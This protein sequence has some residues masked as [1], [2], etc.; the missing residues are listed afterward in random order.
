M[1]IDFDGLEELPQLNIRK[2]V[3]AV[4]NEGA[5]IASS[6]LKRA[7]NLLDLADK[8]DDF[9]DRLRRA[10]VALAQI[11]KETTE[12]IS[13]VIGAEWDISSPDEDDEDESDE[14]DSD[15]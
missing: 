3:T 4:I 13:E 15:D 12:D 6:Y 2:E 11:A 9:A 14:E 1:G 7:E 8:H 10:A 5:A